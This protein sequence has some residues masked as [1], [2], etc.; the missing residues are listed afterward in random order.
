MSLPRSYDA[1]LYSKKTLRDEDIR[2]TAMDKWTNPQELVS[3]LLS[4][5]CEYRE[6][7][8]KT[9]NGV[10]CEG[11]E[12][13][14]P[15]IWDG[16]FPIKSLIGRMWVSVETGYPVL[17]ECEVTGGDDGNVHRT[18]K[19]DQFQWN[20]NLDESDVEPEIPSGYECID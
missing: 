20:V 12:T 4:L 9:I 17:L 14:D 11:L 5:E 15:T 10:L 19:M 16:S 6:L 2:R 13:T 18:T 3:H 7:S 1:K 8:K